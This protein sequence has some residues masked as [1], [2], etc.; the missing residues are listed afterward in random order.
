MT[1]LVPIR[2]GKSTQV[3]LVDIQDRLDA[4]KQI[5]ETRGTISTR[6]AMVER[7]KQELAVDPLGS[8]VEIQDAA[9]DLADTFD[10][11]ITV[12]EAPFSKEQIQ[13]ISD[14]FVALE[15]L[16]VQIEAL[17]ESRY[18]QLVF[19][20][21]DETVKPVPGR[22]VPQIPGKMA[23]EGPGPHYIF[24]RRGGNRANPDLNVET[25][26]DDLPAEVAAQVYVTIHHPPVPAWDE[27]VFDEGKFGELVDAGIIDLD[28]VAPHLTP[29]DWR[30]PSFYKTRV[31]GDE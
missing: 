29:G 7:A 28:V 15:R 13:K 12:D 24:E 23:A 21:L 17:T 22:P 9:K 31:E 8:M 16:R 25:L 14:E 27:K 6:K 26:H 18:R 3:S 19:A 5:A 11:S 30:T 2:K 1:D 10:P 4:R 20:H